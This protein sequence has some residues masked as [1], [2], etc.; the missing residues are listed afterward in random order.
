MRPKSRGGQFDGNFAPNRWGGSFTEGSA[1]HHSFPPF[2]VDELA[3]LHG[4]KEK[5]LRKL[6]E[7]LETPGTFQV[8]N[9][10]A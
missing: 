8:R 1:W 4:G 10:M 5:L 3:R 2:A 6:H 7:M 9:K